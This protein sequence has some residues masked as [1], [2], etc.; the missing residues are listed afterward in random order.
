[1]NGGFKNK[2]KI[3]TNI[4]ALTHYNVA[5]QTTTLV[6]T[7]NLVLVSQTVCVIKVVNVR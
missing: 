2:A 6:P 4:S 7:V 1:M 3:Y 5:A